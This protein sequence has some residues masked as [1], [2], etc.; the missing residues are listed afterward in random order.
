[1]GGFQL[2]LVNYSGR[3]VRCKL[4]VRETGV[5]SLATTP[6]RAGEQW[7]MMAWQK[8]TLAEQP[9]V[10]RRRHEGKRAVCQTERQ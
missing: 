6:W 3:V 5:H 4:W 1:M 9:M 7:R 10:L 2:H 8:G